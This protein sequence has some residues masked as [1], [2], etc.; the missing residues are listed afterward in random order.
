LNSNMDSNEE[1]EVI[2]IDDDESTSKQ[3]V[4]EVSETSDL[5]C[6]SPLETNEPIEDFRHLCTFL[7][8]KSDCAKFYFNMDRYTSK[9]IKQKQKLVVIGFDRSVSAYALWAIF[10][11]F[12]T[13]L[14]ITH[15]GSYA[16][17]AFSNGEEAL[18]ARMYSH[19]LNVNDCV[20]SVFSYGAVQL[21]DRRTIRFFSP[22]DIF[23]P[24]E[25]M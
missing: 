18:T 7:I 6:Y 5:P 17:I 21:E 20:I 14:Y 16:I 25:D 23:N 11:K 24:S 8:R 15:K 10:H 12:G 3:S 1:D 4:C 2:V 13:V 19:G 9:H 22:A